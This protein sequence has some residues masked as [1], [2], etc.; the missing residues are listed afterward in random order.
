[1]GNKLIIVFFCFFV[2]LEPKNK[3]M[4]FYY[5]FNMFTVLNLINVQLIFITSHN[6]QMFTTELCL[7]EI[8]ELAFLTRVCNVTLKR[9]LTLKRFLVLDITALTLFYL[10]Q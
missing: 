4:H 9:V 2:D 1:M 6:S 8:G 3:K 5:M 10:S 7:M